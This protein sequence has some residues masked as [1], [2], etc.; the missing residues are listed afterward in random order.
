MPTEKPRVTFMI[1]EEKLAE[2]ES[3]RFDNKIKN[4]SQAILSLID[5]GLS[6]LEAEKTVDNKNSPSPTE[7]EPGEDTLKLMEYLRRA[8]YDIGFLPEGE[9]LTDRQANALLGVC[10]IL[11]AI[12]DEQ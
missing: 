7:A 12:F 8:V 10:A 5:K 3:Y 11:H 6:A 4:Q 2:L 1:S 9:D